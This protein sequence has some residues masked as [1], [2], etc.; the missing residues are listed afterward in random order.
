MVQDSGLIVRDDD[1]EIVRPGRRV[2][3][4]LSRG[5]VTLRVREIVHRDSRAI[6]E[7]PCDVERV[8]L[9]VVRGEV[10]GNRLTRQTEG[11]VAEPVIQ[12]L[13]LRRQVCTG[14][15]ARDDRGRRARA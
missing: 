7:V 5:L 14:P 10:E 4:L 13:D 11:G 9:R 12:A 3:V 1:T 6:P 8:T 2:R 15:P